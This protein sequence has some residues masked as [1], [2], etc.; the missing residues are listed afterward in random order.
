MWGACRL[1]FFFTQ[2]FNI[3]NGSKPTRF[4]QRTLSTFSLVLAD[5]STYGTPHC[6][7]R[8][9]HSA[10][11]TFRLSFRSHLLPTNRNGMLSSFF[12]RKICSLKLNKKMLS[13]TVCRKYDYFTMIRNDYS[14]T[15]RN[16]NV[17]WKL[18][19]SVIENTQR[20]PSPLRK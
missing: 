20:K 18:S 4:V 11:G 16:S 1:V 6:W 10:N 9:W 15:H 8:P 13:V 7:A 14:T 17:D 5:V 3:E 12:T 2:Q 19:S